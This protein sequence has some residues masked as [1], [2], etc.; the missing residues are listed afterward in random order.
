MGTLRLDVK[1]RPAALLQV[2][3]GMSAGITTR[4]HYSLQNSIMKEVLVAGV[5]SSQRVG[6]CQ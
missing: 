1:A 5:G 6:H 2:V 3:P 4:R